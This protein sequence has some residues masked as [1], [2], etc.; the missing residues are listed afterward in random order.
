MDESMLEGTITKWLKQCGDVVQ[1]GEPLFEISTDKVDAEIPSPATGVL[2]EIKFPAGNTVPNNT[3]IGEI[4]EAEAT[5][6]KS[7]SAS[8]KMP[9]TGTPDDRLRAK[10]QDTEIYGPRCWRITKILLRSA[11]RFFKITLIMLFAV[12]VVVGILL[13]IF[14]ALWHYWK[15]AARREKGHFDSSLPNDCLFS[16]LE[17]VTWLP[18]LVWGGLM[19]VVTPPILGLIFAGEE[20]GDFASLHRLPCMVASC[21]LAFGILAWVFY[22]E[23]QAEF[24][25]SPEQQK[26]TTMSWVMGLVVIIALTGACTGWTHRH[27][28]TMRSAVLIIWK[29]SW[30]LR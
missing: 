14:M 15:L 9:S 17:S 27:H 24:A 7:V 30:G 12:F 23:W 2:S 25:G 20:F 28:V 22:K 6:G 1:F 11:W 5:P 13:S 4:S 8:T 3:V 26:T 16:F 19:L 29:V 10:A 18:R 21:F